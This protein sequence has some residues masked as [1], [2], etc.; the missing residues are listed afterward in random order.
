MTDGPDENSGAVADEDDLFELFRGH[1][2]DPAAF[3]AGIDR[4]VREQGEGGTEAPPSHGIWAKVAS[5]VPLDPVTGTAGAGVLAKAFGGKLL[6]VAFLLPALFLGAVVGTFG[7]AARDLRR[8]GAQARDVTRPGISDPPDD[9]SQLPWWIVWAPV[10]VLVL[11]ALFGHSIG[12]DL[13]IGLLVITM[14]S[15]VCLV[16]GLNESGR[17]RRRT[18]AKM[19]NGLFGTMVASGFLHST[20]IG[21][22]NGHSSL[23]SGA[24]S[25]V[26]LVGWAAILALNTEL[27][28]KRL[29]APALIVLGLM[30]GLN[31]VGVTHSDAAGLRAT[32]ARIDLVPNEM[33]G[34]DEVAT[35]HRALS[36]AGAALPDHGGL[37][38]R[39][40]SDASPEGLWFSEMR[41][42][43]LEMGLVTEEEWLAVDPRTE[44]S[45]DETTAR[46]L[47]V[48]PALDDHG[49]L[50][51]T[52]SCVR[53]LERVG[54]E[55]KIKLLRSKAR[56]LLEERFLNDR[57]FGLFKKA[58]G[59][60]D[61]LESRY[62]EAET[63]RAAVELMCRFGVPEGV[64]LYLLRGY[65]RS[66]ARAFSAFYDVM[67]ESKADT[68]AALFRL[69]NEIGMP[70]RS[71]LAVLFAERLFIAAVL[72]VILA[73]L[74]VWWSPPDEH[75]VNAA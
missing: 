14:A 61:S 16:R 56:R 53:A 39:V 68:R 29:V 8:S 62:P 44:E 55:D 9:Q 36:A 47:R 67:P 6:S 4:S 5:I 31:G 40:L 41:S 37:R 23:G 30:F 64:D 11:V 3:R 73:L 25:A 45:A 50:E 70:E 46:I 42:A 63:T 69:E 13:L 28:R 15:V 35:I 24:V 20:Q 66:E 58:G 22:G 27:G 65:L 60:T 48:V 17:L 19:V 54:A 43:T 52:V 49:A 2:P 21:V 72:T 57:G 75:E 74:A 26:I 33:S 32:A 59:F 34:W 12:G 10:L 38:E 51:E 7:A 1:A 18:V 71:W